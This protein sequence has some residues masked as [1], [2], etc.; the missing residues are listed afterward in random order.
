MKEIKVE[1]F[2]Y[3]IIDKQELEGAAAV[4]IYYDLNEVKDQWDIQTFAKIAEG[5]FDFY[6]SIGIK[7][8]FVPSLCCIESLD[9]CKTIIE[10]LSEE[11]YEFSEKQ[12]EFFAKR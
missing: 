5:I 7:A 12:D 9:D 11:L 10:K 3:K 6:K 2:T 4:L 8:I 1:N